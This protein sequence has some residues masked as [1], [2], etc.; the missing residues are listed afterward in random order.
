MAIVILAAGVAAMPALAESAPEAAL[1]LPGATAQPL[2]IDFADDPVLKLSRTTQVGDAFRAMVASA[3]ARSPR[4]REAEAGAAEARAGRGE[5]RAGLFPAV[6]LSVVSDRMLDRSFSNNPDNFL[7]RIRPSGRTDARLSVEQRLFDFGATSRRIQSANAMLLA[8]EAGIE[9]ESVEVALATISAF[10][11]VYGY[12]ALVQFGEGASAGQREI[13]DA[14]SE[15]IRSGVAAEGDRARVD[16]FI[17]A[18]D[19][20]TARF[21]RSLA[22]AEAR[23]AHLTGAPP[24]A[25][26]IRPAMVLNVPLT[27]DLAAAAA[28]QTAPV[29]VAN[30]RALSARL[31]A[32][33]AQADR[34]PKVSAQVDAG[35]F[36][37]LEGGND[38]DV[39]GRVILS[40]RFFGGIEAA[41]DKAEARAR[42]GSATADRVREESDR[43]A[44]IAWSDV[45]TLTDELAALETSYMASRR[46][47]DVLVE[48]FRVARGDLFELLSAEDKYFET[49]A[50]YIQRLTELDGARFVLLARSGRLLDAFNTASARNRADE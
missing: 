29:R 7:E 38:Y 47:R 35:R 19:A 6:E 37:I 8:A 2:A 34:L 32:R 21:R 22:E 39:R 18:A 36:G 33:A 30:A 50:T 31:D 11:E 42:L 45:R 13:G 25:R 41:A 23:L 44:R 20:R 48:R 10:Y 12:R 14:V 28:I 17:A 15:R 43:D 9:Q 5:A 16:A 26:L 40:Q 27:A 1:A 49:A 3:V 46:S 4:L 24:P